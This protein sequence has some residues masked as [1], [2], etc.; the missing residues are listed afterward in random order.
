MVRHKYYHQRVK[1][2]L[3]FIIP[4][5]K[6]VLIFGAQGDFKRKIKSYKKFDYIF[7]NGT[8]NKSKDLMSLLQNLQK[9]CH[10]STRILIYQHNYLWQWILTLAE[11]FRLK[12]REG[13]QNWLS[14]DDTRVYLSGS[15]F[16]VTRIFKK[17]ICPVFA[18]GLGPLINWTAVILPFFDFFKLDQFILA[19]PLPELFPEVSQDSLTICIT[20]R[21]EQG[22]IEKIVKALPIV[23]RKQEIFLVEGHSTDGTR[24]EIERMIRK[25]PEKNIRVIG[26]PGSGQGDAIRVGFKDAKGDIIILYEGDGT[27][28]TGDVKY[29]YDAM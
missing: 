10:P 29:F 9:F 15:G 28:D 11:R 21:N 14:I 20:V 12:R 13:V 24:E 16:E 23:C 8:L 19:R 3:D 18:F 1:Q 2:T 4:K 6:K 25:Y 7:L 26:Q 22:N 17:T 27:S 5:D